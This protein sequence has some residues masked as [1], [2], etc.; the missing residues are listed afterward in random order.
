MLTWEKHKLDLNS[1]VQGSF[2]GWAAP[3]WAAVE[4]FI[5]MAQEYLSSPPRT[6]AACTSPVTSK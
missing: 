3:E 6:T 4:G 1:R 5:G 2:W